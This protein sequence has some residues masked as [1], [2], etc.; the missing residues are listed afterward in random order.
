MKMFCD[1]PNKLRR[2]IRNVIDA[3]NADIRAAAADGLAMDEHVALTGAMVETTLR[4]VPA[5][6][7]RLCWDSMV[8]IMNRKFAQ[9]DL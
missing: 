5:P 9:G 3:Y 1:D 6:M 7:R 4:N 2:Q 8:A